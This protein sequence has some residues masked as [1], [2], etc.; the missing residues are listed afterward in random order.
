MST[1]KRRK[2]RNCGKLF[3]PDPRN[4]RHQRYCSASAFRRASKAASQCRWLSKAANREYFR[5]PEQVARVGELHGDNERRLSRRTPSALSA[6]ALPGPVRIIELHPPA[7]RARVVASDLQAIGTCAIHEMTIEFG[8]RV[9]CVYNP[10]CHR[11]CTLGRWRLAS[12]T[13]L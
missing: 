2:C 9:G 8:S 7:Q 10:L 13:D 3:R 1:R 12:D 5:G 11:V 6:A 4:V